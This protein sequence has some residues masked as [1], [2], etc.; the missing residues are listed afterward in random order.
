MLNK[1]EK[2]LKLMTPLPMNSML[3]KQSKDETIQKHSAR[4]AMTTIDVPPTNPGTVCMTI[5]TI[6][7]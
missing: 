5:K 7:S 1:A 2:D 4:K 6:F 3:N